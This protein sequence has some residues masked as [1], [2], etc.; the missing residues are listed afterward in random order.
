GESGRPLRPGPS[1]MNPSA[2]DVATRTLL[3]LLPEILV[4]LSATAMMTAGAF[5][6]L[7]RRVWSSTA[8][9]VLVAALIALIAVRQEALDPYSAVALNDAL[10]WYARLAFVL[11]GL[12]L[13][14]LAHDQVEEA[15]AA[16]FFGA[17]LMI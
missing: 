4:M 16:E 3:V 6:Q 1:P 12:I 10:S 13:I 17:L 9:G 11:T 8:A 7:P 14:A 2:Y 15:R 5:V